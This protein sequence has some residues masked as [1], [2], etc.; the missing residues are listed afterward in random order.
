[1]LNNFFQ[2]VGT[3]DDGLSPSFVQRSA[4]SLGI[5]NI[6]FTPEVVYKQI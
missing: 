5:K 6:V 2:S 4:Y 1:L 3:A